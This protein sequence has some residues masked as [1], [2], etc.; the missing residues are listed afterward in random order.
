MKD[1][2]RVCVGERDE[3]VCGETWGALTE[4]SQFYSERDP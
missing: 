4:R 3:E 2:V 1:R